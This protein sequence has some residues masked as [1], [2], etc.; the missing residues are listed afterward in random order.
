MHRATVLPRIRGWSLGVSIGVMEVVTGCITI[1]FSV[2]RFLVHADGSIELL[3]G[4]F[5]TE[6]IERNPG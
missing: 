5:R 3:L 4:I 6:Q 1:H 2:P